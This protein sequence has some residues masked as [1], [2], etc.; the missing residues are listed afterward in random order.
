[1]KK[2]LKSIV[3][4]AVAMVAGSEAFAQQT[5]QATASA[6]A[7]IVTPIQI[8]NVLDMSFGNVASGSTSGTVVLATNGSR[9]RTGGVTLPA[10]GGTVNAATFNVSGEASYT[11]TITL[12]SG[13]F[14]LNGPSSNTM[15][16]GTFVSDPNG[17][18]T[19]GSGGTDA[20]SVGATLSVG[21]NQAPGTYTAAS[22]FPVIVQYN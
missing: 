16:I 14:T 18:S 21:A 11:Y 17:S 4:A 13:T 2:V 22:E 5:S 15:T 1:M 3:L 10:T 8:T 20:I 19:L 9:T 6:S 12:P 7:T